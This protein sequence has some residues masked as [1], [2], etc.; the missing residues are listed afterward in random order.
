[1]LFVGIELG[2]WFFFVNTLHASEYV[3]LPYNRTLGEEFH[4][5]IEFVFHCVCVLCDL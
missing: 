2:K 1:M 3:Y 4:E 5:V